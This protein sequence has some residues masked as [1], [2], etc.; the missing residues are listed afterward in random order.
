M[1]GSDIA[2][3]RKRLNVNELIPSYL[4]EAEAYSFDDILSG[5]RLHLNESP[6]PPPRE[7]LEKAAQRLS[8]VNKYIHPSV[9]ERFRELVAEY[10]K[11]EPGNVL[12]TA[13]GDG[14][15]KMVLYN[16]ANPGDRVVLNYPSY[17]MFWVYSKVRG[18]RVE[19]VSLREDGE[20]WRED[21]DS[22][23][24]KARGA[25][26]V[27]ID[28][29]NN[30]TGSPMLQAKEELIESLA[31]AVDGFVLIDEAYHEFAG[32]TA[33]KMV[34]EIPNLLIVRTFSKAFSM[35]S[36]RVG[37]LLGSREVIRNLQKAWTPFDVNV[38]GYV[39]A[40]TAL[41]NP[42][43][44]RELV[45]QV[46]EVREE[47]LAS[48]R[49]LGLRAYNSVTNFVLFRYKGNLL[50]PLMRNGFAIRKLWEDFY[51]VSVGTREQVRELIKVMGDVLEDSG[52][53]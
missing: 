23:I 9:A 26:L 15:I 37:Y 28:D 43:Y 53:E 11:V 39:A 48:L 7:V 8:E 22:L 49:R 21:F 33:A 32:Y 30:P 14:A 50:D 1:E 42:S 45:R 46:S 10:C 27:V 44:V 40:I 38:I 36:L 24:E 17:S 12:P 29:P 20:W 25:K 52:S 31:E 18:F 51:R 3:T 41:E 19:K 4:K 35:A 16:L 2:P 6:L 13:G 47:L 34:E 5:V